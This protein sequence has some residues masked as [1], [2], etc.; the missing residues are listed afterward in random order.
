MRREKFSL[1]KNP[2]SGGQ[3]QKKTLRNM[4][5]AAKGG[6]ATPIPYTSGSRLRPGFLRTYKARE[7]A[8]VFPCTDTNKGKEKKGKASGVGLGPFSHKEKKEASFFSISKRGDL[9]QQQKKSPWGRVAI[10]TKRKRRAGERIKL[11]LSGLL[12][13]PFSLSVKEKERCHGKTWRSTAQY[14]TR[15]RQGERRDCCHERG[16]KKTAETGT[17]IFCRCFRE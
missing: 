11:P 17:T 14:E 5:Q 12:S 15:N 9:S 4:S 3:Q 16:K 7:T 1:G 8:P 10:R 2:P 6:K 13:F